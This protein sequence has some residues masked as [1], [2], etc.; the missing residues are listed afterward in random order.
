MTI[1]IKLIFALCFLLSATTLLQAQVGVGTS[2]P[3]ASAQLDVSSTTKGFLPP[4]VA[5]VSTDN[6]SSP[7][8]SPATG[9]LVYNTAEVGSGAT[10]VTPGY[11]YY[12]GSA[13]VPLTNGVKKIAGPINISSYSAGDVVYDQ[14]SANYYFFKPEVS[15]SSSSYSNPTSAFPIFDV[16]RVVIRMRPDRSQS[17]ASITLKTWGVDNGVLSM[18]SGLGTNSASCSSS[19]PVVAVDVNTLM[20]SSTSTSGSGYVTFTFATPISVTANTDYYLT[21]SSACIAGAGIEVVHNTTS[22]NFAISY[23]GTT[24]DQGIPAI[25]INGISYVV[26]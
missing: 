17:I 25:R 13:W 16:G 22:T 18:Y 24:I 2:T 6:T 19:N 20:G 3:A 1:T 9:L 5:L 4:R 7:I 15:Q 11:Y 10:A 26:L 14:S 12:S 21:F 8:S 23:G